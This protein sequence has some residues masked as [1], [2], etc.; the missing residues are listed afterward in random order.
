MDQDDIS[1]AEMDDIEDRG[2]DRFGVQK[3]YEENAHVLCFFQQSIYK[4]LHVCFT[5]LV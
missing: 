5:Q 1:Q 3:V 4:H 2:Q